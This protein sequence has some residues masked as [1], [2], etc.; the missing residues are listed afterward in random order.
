MFHALLARAVK[1]AG[2]KQA[3]AKAIGVTP[4]RF[5]K[6]FHAAPGSYTLGVRNCFRLAAL[7]REPPQVVLRAVGKK[8]LADALDD[9][10]REVS[11]GRA[12]VATAA[13]AED[14]LVADLRTAL[15]AGVDRTLA[16]ALVRTI[17]GLPLQPIPKRHSGRSRGH[18]G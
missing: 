2:Q 7:L 13:P 18:A 4:S 3:A 16:G 8:D 11:A 17:Q 6:L 12:R 5:S 14:P 1:E 9:Y 10:A 15:A